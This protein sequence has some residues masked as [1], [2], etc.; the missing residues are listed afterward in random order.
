[1]SAFADTPADTR[2]G[3]ATLAAPEET[4]TAGQRLHG[5]LAV[6][7]ILL[8][9][10]EIFEHID[11][12]V[13]IPLFYPV[14]GLYLMYFVTTRP[15][16]IGKLAMRPLFLMWALTAII[17]IMMYMLGDK[18]AAAWVSL[19]V[20]LVC[21]SVIGGTAMVLMDPGSVSIVRR[22]AMIA[23]AIAIPI[24]LVEL[25]VPNLL[26]IS[27]GRSAGFY[28]NPNISAA[29]IIVCVILAVDFTKHTKLGFFTIGMAAVA[30]LTTFS[31]AG[32]LFIAVLG[33]AYVMLP[34]GRESL[35]ALQRI[36]ILCAGVFAI[37]LVI[38]LILNLVD[39]S[40]GARARLLSVIYADFTD[41]SSAERLAAA[42]WAFDQFLEY[43]WTGRGL[44]A[45]EFYD[46]RTHNSFVHI[47]VEYGVGGLILYLV[48]LFAGLLKIAQHGWNRAINLTLLAGFLFYNS[49]FDHYVHVQLPFAIAF[50][51]IMI[52]A[53]I[54]KQNAGTST[55]TR[56]H[57]GALSA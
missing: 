40:A 37:A 49:A 42:R 55:D 19:R 4:R 52:D 47:G 50:S 16:H 12:A 31:R 6:S 30:I 20:R 38:A 34:K 51:V 41:E 54:P 36:A 7:W 48:I 17:P 18:S 35:S 8:W 15:V 23:L 32:I 14:I 29:V 56:D 27:P 10:T 3:A 57:L 44:G 43:F 24:N 9:L 45:P 26:S 1:V 28:E 46:M 5:F 22:A 53:L 25:V 2:V 11:R 21:F 13:P 39:L 33:V